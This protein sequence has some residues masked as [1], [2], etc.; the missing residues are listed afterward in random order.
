MNKLARNLRVKSNVTTPL[1]KAIQQAAF[2]SEAGI[3]L[4]TTS[5]KAVDT[6]FMRA[7]TRVT[8]FK[9]GGDAMATVGPTAEY[10]I[11]VHEGTRFVKS[12]PFIPLGVKLK[13][14]SLD[15]LM[16]RTG[17]KIGLNLVSGVE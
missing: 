8:S 2:I 9:P 16:K 6:G 1:E 3:K 10:S 15:S 7:S 17:I 12:R 5:V 11:Y 4:A 14:K 13:S